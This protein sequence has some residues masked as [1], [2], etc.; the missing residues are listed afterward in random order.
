MNSL[1]VK[2]TRPFI[3]HVTL[4]YIEKELSAQDKMKL[5]AVVNDINVNL[6]RKTRFFVMSNAE[7]R[8]YHH[9]AEFKKE[10]YYPT[11]YFNP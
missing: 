2:M 10:R 4:A 11:F 9:L 7:L 8:R 6:S 1:D 5:A 3:G